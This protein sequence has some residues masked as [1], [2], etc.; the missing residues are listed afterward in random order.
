MAIG[1]LAPQPDEESGPFWEGLTRGV[2][3]L[4]VC[5]RCGRRRFPRI[6]SCPYCGMVGGDD[7]AVRGTGTVYSW[8][9]VHRAMTPNVASEDVP[10]VVATV[11]LDGGG[12][13]FGRLVAGADTD[14]SVGHPVEPV[15]T[16]HGSWT[17][18]QF[19]LVPPT[20]GAPS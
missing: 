7:V 18:L 15:F 11:D 16:D 9:R 13:M 6:P 10:Y 20:A 2:V 14:V 1:D 12:R 5:P 4:L 19:A 3:L 8:V 17:E